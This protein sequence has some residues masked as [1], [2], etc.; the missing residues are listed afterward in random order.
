MLYEPYFGKCGLAQDETAAALL[1]AEAA[2]Y[3]RAVKHD[4]GILEED[5]KET[6]RIQETELR[7]ALQD[8]YM[9]ILMRKAAK[10]GEKVCSDKR[11]WHRD[12][13]TD[14][15]AEKMPCAIK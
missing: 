15:K 6:I 3:D 9:A 5:A 10:T 8:A 12:S 14:N 13:I 11:G 4:E 2:E 1:M 7:N